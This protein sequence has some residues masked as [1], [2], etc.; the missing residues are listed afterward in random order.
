L[1]KK[2]IKSGVRIEHGKRVDTFQGK[3]QE[4]VQQLIQSVDSDG[5]NAACL[6]SRHT[7]VGFDDR[8]WNDTGTMLFMTFYD[9]VLVDHIN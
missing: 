6:K 2:N 8:D 4:E 3:E 7:Q 1:V 9:Q 5:N